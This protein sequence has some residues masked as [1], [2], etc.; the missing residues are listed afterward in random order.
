MSHVQTPADFFGYTTTARAILVECKIRNETRLELG[1]GGLKP[2][3]LRSLRELHRI[4]GVALLAW[5]RGG[6]RNM[7]KRVALLDPDM[8]EAFS[9]GRKSIP[10]KAIPMKHIFLMREF[11]KGLETAIHPVAV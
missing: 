8:I 6:V 7:V 2:H 3:Q 5:G 10:W 11:E 9:E 1:P 4:N